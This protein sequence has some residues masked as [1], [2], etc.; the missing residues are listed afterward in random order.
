MQI[1]RAVEV[2]RTVERGPEP[3]RR[4]ASPLNDHRNPCW[5][6]ALTDVAALMEPPVMA[7]NEVHRADNGGRPTYLAKY[8]EWSTCGVC[9]ETDIYVQAE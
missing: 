2:T 6:S 4:P 7:S 9:Y 5:W 3:D 8:Y 1:G